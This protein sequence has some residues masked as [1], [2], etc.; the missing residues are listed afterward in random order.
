MDD[1]KALIK[2]LDHYVLSWVKRSTNKVTHSLAKI[3][4]FT[5]DQ[6]SWVTSTPAFIVDVLLH[7]LNN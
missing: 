3:V 6:E 1:C 2:S 5:F 4:Y 7:D